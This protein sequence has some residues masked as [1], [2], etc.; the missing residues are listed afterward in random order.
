MTENWKIFW[1]V[2][3][4]EKEKSRLPEQSK[5]KSNLYFVVC[6]CFQFDH[7]IFLIDLVK[8]LAAV[9]FLYRYE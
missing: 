2:E 5:F 4:G 3:N 1:S 6:K 9:K 7:S 8:S